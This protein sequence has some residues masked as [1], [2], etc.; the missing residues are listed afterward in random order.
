MMQLVAQETRRARDWIKGEHPGADEI[1]LHAPHVNFTD[2]TADFGHF[3]APVYVWTDVSLAQ[4]AGSHQGLQKYVN[5]CTGKTNKQHQLCVLKSRHLS[6]KT[7]CR[8]RDGRVRNVGQPRRRRRR[9]SVGVRGHCRRF[10]AGLDQSMAAWVASMGGLAG[11]YARWA[12][13][14]KYRYRRRLLSEHKAYNAAA[15][16]SVEDTYWSN[17][18]LPDGEEVGASAHDLR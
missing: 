7:G 15:G 2:S 12:P 14:A 8:R 6:H 9:G 5:G 11:L 16:A 18:G 10:V 3:Y 17:L 1:D 4:K 13:H